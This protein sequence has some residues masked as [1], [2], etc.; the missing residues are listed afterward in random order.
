MFRFVYIEME[1]I[2]D[3]ISWNEHFKKKTKLS[4]GQI[5]WDETKWKLNS[6]G[7]VRQK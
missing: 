1:P 4:K 7:K 6:Q 3:R 2:Q 5:D